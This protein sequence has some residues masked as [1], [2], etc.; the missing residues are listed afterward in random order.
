MKDR[1][2][3]V[4]AHRGARSG[5]I[6]AVV[7]GANDGIVSISSLSIGLF[8][9]GTAH[10]TVVTAT[11]AALVAGAMSMAA[12]EYVSVSS[13]ADV[14]AADI[15][16]EQ[17]EHQSDPDGELRELAEIYTSRGVPD[18]LARQ[19]ATA[20]TQHDPVGAHVRDE[21]GET[22]VN[23]ARPLQAALSSSLSFSLGGLLPFLALVL[24]PARV[25]VILMIVM[26]IGALVLL[27]IVAARAGGSP[28]RRAV[29]RIGI[30]G[31]AAIAVTAGVS[32]L[33]GG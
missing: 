21:L 2:A 28:V 20:L 13:Q 29:V 17:A 24:S 5:W 15:A 22:S 7:L 19:V 1:P 10:R 4:V 32:Q 11:L 12:G 26:S 27:G 18:G 31:M 3:E 14:T 30:G 6:R 25:R 8:A 33:F 9:A 16:Q 23:Q